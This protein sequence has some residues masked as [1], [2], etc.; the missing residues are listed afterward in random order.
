MQYAPVLVFLEVICEK[1]PTE[2]EVDRVDQG[3]VGIRVVN[4]NSQ[5]NNKMNPSHHKLNSVRVSDS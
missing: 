3:K 4:K 1:S 5:K 2:E